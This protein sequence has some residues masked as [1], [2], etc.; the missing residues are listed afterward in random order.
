MGGEGDMADPATSLDY[1]DPRY[2]R[3][4]NCFKSLPHDR[5]SFVS[6]TSVVDAYGHVI[7]GCKF[8]Y[9]YQ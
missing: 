3:S 9:K 1:R 7:F 2:K 8:G 5:V 6:A 4:W